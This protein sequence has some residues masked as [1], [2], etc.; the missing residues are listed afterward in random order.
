LDVVVASEDVFENVGDFFLLANPIL[1]MSPDL[2]NA[3]I[4][5]FRNKPFTEARGFRG[6]E[7]TVLL[8][9]LRFG[10][11]EVGF[12]GLGD[13]CVDVPKTGDGSFE[14]ELFGV[15]G[16]LLRILDGVFSD[17]PTP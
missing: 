3:G 7:A 13:R 1:S 12:S 10:V 8:P 5:G 14:A 16:M 2:S 4:E 11:F 6:L 15:E 9:G 17:F